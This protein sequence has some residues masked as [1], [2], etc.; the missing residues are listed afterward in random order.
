M[1]DETPSKRREP[2]ASEAMFFFAIVKHTRNKADIDWEAVAQEQNFKNA[3]VAKV[4]FGQVKRKLGIDSNVT[5]KKGNA[6]TAIASTP[7]KVRKT[8]AGRAGAKGRGRGA[9]AKKEDD[10]AAAF[11]AETGD[12]TTTA[13][14]SPFPKGEE[15]DGINFKAEHGEDPF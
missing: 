8:P 10:E 12:D 14:E 6:S 13:V 15:D 2:T 9:R 5:P 7:S 3:E 1:A 4:R 11:D